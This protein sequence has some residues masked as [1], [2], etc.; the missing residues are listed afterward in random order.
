MMRLGVVLVV[1]VMC[2]SQG[3][4]RA[5]SQRK[6]GRSGRESQCPGKDRHLEILK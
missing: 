2:R 3:G 5:Q 6:T 4:R 1:V